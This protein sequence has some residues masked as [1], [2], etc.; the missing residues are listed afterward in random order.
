M[1]KDVPDDLI[2]TRRSL[3]TRLKDWEDQEGWQ[4]FFD[5]DWKLIYGVA[6]KSGLTDAE[7]Q[8]VVQ[9][10]VL[11]VAKR[12]HEFKCDPALGSFKG[13][14]CQLTRWKV[15]GQF[16]RRQRDVVPHS[17][18]A[19]DPSPIATVERLPDPESLDL[20]RLWD[21]EWRKNLMDAA[22]RRIKR[23]VNAKDFQTF[24][25]YV[26]KDWPVQEVVETLKV[27]ADQ[28]YQAK[29]RIMPLLKD[30][31]EYLEKQML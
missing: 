23:K 28:V 20:D 12:M 4:R 18:A 8:D 3:L 25:F 5:T 22:L 14:L 15:V 7:A 9:E 16:R 13:W 1:T 31:V 17:P 21:E 10:T 30:E 6:V 2:P 19:E 26:P 29:C 27:T 24:H 11:A